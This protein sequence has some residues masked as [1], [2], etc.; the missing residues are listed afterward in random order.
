M[1]KTITVSFG[2]DMPE[3][4]LEEIRQ[5]IRKILAGESVPEA[6]VVG[7]WDPTGGHG[8]VGTSPGAGLRD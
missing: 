3:D 6:E 7:Q 2:Q 5:K 1:S 4:K 8:S